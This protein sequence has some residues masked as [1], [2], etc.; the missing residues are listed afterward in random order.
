MAQV[1]Q[2]RHDS[3]VGLEAVAIFA[4]C[5]RAD[6]ND[7][8]ITMVSI[9]DILIAASR[10]D[11]ESPYVVCVELADMLYAEVHFT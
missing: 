10:T 1:L 4:R 8:G 6:K 5:E 11:W 9:H 7:I 3:S 2:A